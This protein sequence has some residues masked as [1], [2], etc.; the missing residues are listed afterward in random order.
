MFAYLFLSVSV[1][2]PV[3]VGGVLGSPRRDDVLRLV[4]SNMNPISHHH[5]HIAPFLQHLGTAV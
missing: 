2:I 5:P 3:P 1:P 4:L